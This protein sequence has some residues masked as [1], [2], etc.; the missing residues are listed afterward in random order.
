M[1]R[2]KR[3]YAFTLIVLGVLCIACTKFDSKDSNQLPISKLAYDNLFGKENYVYIKENDEYEPYMVLSKDYYG[4]TLLMRKFLLDETRAFNIYE[5]DGARN[6]YYPN[7]LMDV[8]LSDEFYNT[9]SPKMK[10]L[11]LEM[12]ID[13]TTEESIAGGP[14]LETEKIKRKIFLLSAYEVDA[15]DSSLEAKEGIKQKYFEESRNGLIRIGRFKDGKTFNY[16]LRTAST[17]DDYTVCGVANDRG[18]VGSVPVD[19]ILAVRPIFCVEG[20]VK[21]YKKQIENIG[22]VYV[23]E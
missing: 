10:E 19:S 15:P 6:A 12:E 3:L 21:V 4:K 18:I 16:W 11:I 17:W 14:V 7:S 1:K 20:D 23:I 2:A 5:R 13:I 22:E 8:F 9:L